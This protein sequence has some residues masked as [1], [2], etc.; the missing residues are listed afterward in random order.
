MR[1]PLNI[2]HVITTL[3]RGGAENH[4]VDLVRGQ[5]FLG[6]NVSVAYLKGD[7]YWV[8]E[9]KSLGIR[10][11]CLNLKFY[12][13]LFPII[14]LRKILRTQ[15]PDIV[16]AHMPPAEIHVRLALIG[17]SN[18]KLIITKHNDEPFYQGPGWRFVAC[19]VAKRACHVIAISEAVQNYVRAVSCFN[20]IDISTVH[21]ALDVE[22]FKM[23]ST[24]NALYFPNHLRDCLGGWVI[25]T[26]ARL[27]PQKALHVLIEGYAKYRH[28][29]TMPSQLVIVGSGELE[30]DL[31]RLAEELGVT[32]H[33]RWTGFRD[34]IP[35][36][37]NSIDLFVLTS[38][39]EGFGLV[40]LE[41]MAASK[42]ILATDVS[43]IPE[44]VIHG[45]SGL[46]VQPNDVSAIANAL[47]FFENSQIRKSYGEA[48]F[49]H[50]VSNFSLP[51]MIQQTMETYHRCM[52]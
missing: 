3:N 12:G 19:W 37:L 43:A 38:I 13:D 47:S 27:V 23:S 16:H 4:L 35:A 40:L 24:D 42:P 51:K 34:D 14:S 28:K 36:I 30:S 49:E 1:R 44:I 18:R 52:N 21:Y 25:C 45:K 10:V 50:V 2:L 33:I 9:L 22:M 8:E 29:A 32:N 11:F 15:Q 39:Y 5:L 6:C 7:A 48:G 17:D 41:A 20:N 31:K 46:L 26:I